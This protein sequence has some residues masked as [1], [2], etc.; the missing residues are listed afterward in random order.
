VS[1]VFFR[2]WVGN[3]YGKLDSTFTKKILVLG[4]SHYIDEADD[5][6]VNGMSESCDFTTGVM[7]DYLDP[8]IKGRWKSTFTKFMNSFVSNSKHSDLDRSE[9]WNSVAFYNYLQIPAGS[10]SRQTQYYDY[11]RDS[12]RSAVLEIINEL[13]PDIIVSWGNKVWDAIPENLGYGNGNVSGSYSN[14][15]FIYPFK[16]RELK[17][18]GITHPS[19]SY[20]SSYWADVFCDLE[21]NL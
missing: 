2:P 14:C 10:L 3:N 17:L 13:D 7:L 15:C 5:V 20:N 11:S 6:V 19:S 21:V 8:N 12:D 9:L 16:Q 18:I 4:D 1:N